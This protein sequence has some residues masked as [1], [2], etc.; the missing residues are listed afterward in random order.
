MKT[1][2]FPTEA[3]GMVHTGSGR[4]VWWTGKVAVGLR[5]GLPGAAPRRLSASLDHRLSADAEQL[6]IV[7]LRHRP[8]PIKTGLGARPV[9][10]PL[11]PERTPTTRLG[12][13][14]DW[15]LRTFAGR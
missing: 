7:L 11:R 6:Q 14:L 13:C 8:K 5:A 12:R 1:P 15:L 10:V 2:T 3:R 9:V 4:P